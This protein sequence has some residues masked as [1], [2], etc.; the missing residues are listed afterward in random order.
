MV[1]IAAFMLLGVTAYGYHHQLSRRES[2]ALPVMS[3][4]LLF[5]L[6]VYLSFLTHGR[7]LTE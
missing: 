6:L 5:L 7:S 3:A 1:Q 4:I 2:A